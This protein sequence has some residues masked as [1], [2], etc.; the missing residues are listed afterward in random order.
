MKKLLL[1]VA[2]L[3]LTSLAFAQENGIR[4][5]KM[6]NWKQVLAK[7]KAENKH[8]FMD[9]FATW[10]GPCKAMDREVYSSEKIGA[11]MNDKFISVKVQS[12]KTKGDSEFVKGWYSDANDM[13]KDYQIISYPSFLFFS[14][15]GKLIHKGEG[16]KSV[17]DLLKLANESIDRSKQLNARIEEFK[18]GKI[19]LKELNDLA[20]SLKTA[21]DDRTAQSVADDYINQYLLK[22]PEQ[23]LYTVENLGFIAKFLG[24]PKSQSFKIFSE[25]AEKI[26]KI[27]GEYQ[28]QNTIM[29]YISRNYLPSETT[30][31]NT[32]PDWDQLEKL[33]I[34][35]F[36]AL[37]RERVFEQRMIYCLNT[38][39]WKDYGVWYQNYL[40]DY[41]KTTIY[42]P[43][44][45]SWTL[46]EHVDDKEV[47]KFAC[48]VVMPNAL[49]RWDA[50]N[51]YR[52][53]DTYA[54]LLYKTGRVQDAI[55][56][57]TKALKMSNNDQVMV[58]TLKKMNDGIQTWP[59][60]ST[61]K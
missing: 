59:L 8:I 41:L 55:N 12:D 9:V 40:K 11:F 27:L 7:A 43:N 32:K 15:D 17:D 46:F 18:K 39:N 31:K 26:N 2:F 29:D 61:N 60:A 5:E 51:D 19:A 50:V 10:C 36:G 16:Y 4:F 53:Y 28:A 44:Y 33:L 30:W 35:K 13:M 38:E 54:N 37:G 23:E 42:D 6:S 14:P 47:L 58:E 48:D 20:L 1:G 21:K 45:L 52:V 22:L 34:G 25:Q 49:E 3:S 24:G 56:W 57:E